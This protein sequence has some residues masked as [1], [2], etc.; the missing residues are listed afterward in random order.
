MDGAFF[1]SVPYNIYLDRYN[2]QINGGSSGGDSS[3]GNELCT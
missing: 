2:I 1:F 3:H